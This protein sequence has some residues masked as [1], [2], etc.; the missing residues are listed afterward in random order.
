MVVDFDCEELYIE[1]YCL[2]L[3][4]SVLVIFLFVVYWV[5]VWWGCEFGGLIGMWLSW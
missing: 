1:G 5:L 3:Y 4:Y 2:V